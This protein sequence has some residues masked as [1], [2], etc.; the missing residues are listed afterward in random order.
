MT[1]LSIFS[2]VLNLYIC[3]LYEMCVCWKVFNS[4][5]LRQTP[6]NALIVINDSMNMV[7]LIGTSLIAFALITGCAFPDLFGDFCQFLM[8][9]AMAGLFGSYLGG[10][11]IALLRLLYIKHQGVLDAFGKSTITFVLVVSQAAYI[12]GACHLR[13]ALLL[14]EK[15]ATQNDLWQP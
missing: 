9:S 12:F 3:V 11:S 6:L 2:L 14:N 7:G 15:C 5:P 13:Q 10:V 8:Y 1:F 4:G